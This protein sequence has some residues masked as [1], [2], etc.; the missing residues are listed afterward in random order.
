MDD[1]NPLPD[2]TTPPNGA[3]N[4]HT[5]QVDTNAAGDLAVVYRNPDDNTVIARVY[6]ADGTPRT[7]SFYVSQTGVNDNLEEL[8]TVFDPV[9]QNFTIAGGVDTEIP[10]AGNTTGGNAGKAAHS[11][12]GFTT[13]GDGNDVIGVM[14]LTS[15][16]VASANTTDT[17]CNG[18]V[19]GLPLSHAVRI[20]S[21]GEPPVISGVDN[22]DLLN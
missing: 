3:K 14:W 8:Y 13:D 12:I 6:N 22:W 10:F 19:K 9:N 11:M 2:S 21:F 7:G 20:I 4:G 17:L 1:L 16:S 18:D 15:S 5:T